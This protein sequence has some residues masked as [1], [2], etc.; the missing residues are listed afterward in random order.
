MI[1]GLDLRR[2]LGPLA[3]GG[4]VA[5]LAYT[6]SGAEPTRLL[7]PPAPEPILVRQLPLPPVAPSNDAGACSAAINPNR[8]GC[9]G[10]HGL[11]QSMAGNQFMEHRR[12]GE[13]GVVAAHTHHA[14]VFHELIP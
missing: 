8:T 11:F 2:G 7:K 9:I 5:I 6:A 12:V 1:L 10:V 4:M 13:G 14:T 3:F